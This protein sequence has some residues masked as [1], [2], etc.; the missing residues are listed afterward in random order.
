VR[1]QAVSKSCDLVSSLLS[2]RSRQR[3]TSRRQRRLRPSNGDS[4]WSGTSSKSDSSLSFWAR[5]RRRGGPRHGDALAVGEGVRVQRHVPPPGG[6]TLGV[7]VRHRSRLRVIAAGAGLVGPSGS[8]LLAELARRGGMAGCS[9]LG[10]GPSRALAGLAKR[11]RRH[12][13]GRVLVDLRCPWPVAGESIA[14]LA[15]LRQQPGLFGQVTSTPPPGGWRRRS[16]S[17]C[18]SGCWRPGPKPGPG[19]GPGG[20]GPSG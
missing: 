9:G 18:W 15:T 1:Y 6:L 5:S 11:Y 10:A 17:R 4:Q 3:R 14:N 16:R 19:S 2:R 7:K 13:P 12:E 8:P 20:W